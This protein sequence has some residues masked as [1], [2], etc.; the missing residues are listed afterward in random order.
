MK[1]SLL[2]CVLL[3]P[4]LLG[5]CQSNTKQTPISS[6]I[7]Y[8]NA[9]SQTPSSPDAAN[10]KEN[11]EPPS[12][13][14][15]VADAKKPTVKNPSPFGFLLGE[16][17]YQEVRRSLSQTENVSL[18]PQEDDFWGSM[19]N[20]ILLK[21]NENH[22]ITATGEGLGIE[23]LNLVKFLFDDSDK[24]SAVIMKLPEHHFNVISN[25]IEAKYPNIIEKKIPHVGDKF[26]KIEVD[27]SYIFIEDRHMGGFTM[28]VTYVTKNSLENAIKKTNK[29]KEAVQ[30]KTR[31]KL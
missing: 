7:A 15:V 29:L 4:V 24:L 3:L 27:D 9:N 31:Q 5:S 21:T 19:D 2:F 18:N 6:E 26:V 30:N 1:K 11:S 10:S 28:I 22:T 23:G 8:H 14:S 12:T 13:H 17:T 16:A 25:L 20:S